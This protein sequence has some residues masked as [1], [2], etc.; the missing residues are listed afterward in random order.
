QLADLIQKLSTVAEAELPNVIGSFRDW[1]FP[2]SDFFVWIPV[3]NRFDGILE[4]II[5]KHDLKHYQ[6]VPFSAQTKELLISV[7]GFSK[8]L[9]DNCTNRNIYAS[10]EHL[11]ELLLTEDADVQEA[12]LRLLQKPAQRLSQQR[13]LKSTLAISQQ[14]VSTIAQPWNTKDIGLDIVELAKP[15]T[16][17]PLESRVVSYQ[18]YRTFKATPSATPST[19]KE[20]NAE[21]KDV[22]EPS[23]PRQS[24]STSSSK[25]LMPAQEGLVLVT[26]HVGEKT[27]RQLF[28]SLADEYGVPEQHK[29]GL[30]H[31]IR[32]TLALGDAERRL[33][34]LRTRLLAI[35]TLVQLYPEDVS[36]T[37]LFLYEPDL[38]QRLVDIAMAEKE[39]PKSVQIVAISTL[40]A[41]ARLRGHLSEVMAALN[42]SANHGPLMI[43]FRKTL[44]GLESPAE[45]SKFPQDYVDAMFSLVSYLTTTQAGGPMITSSGI[46][47][48]L[49]QVLGNESPD[50]I[51]N[52]LR[53]TSILDTIVYGF[54]NGF[55]ILA[56][57]GGLDLVISRIKKEADL[58]VQ[59]AT[60]APAAD[61]ATSTA[62][63]AAA[64]E[65]MDR[66]SLLRA[67]LK[68]VLHMMQTSGTADRLRNLIDSTLPASLLQVLAFSKTFG[69]GVFSLAVNIM[70]TFIHNEPT[71]LS[72]LQELKLPQTF[73]VSIKRH[74]PFSPEVVSA[75]PTA[76]GAICLNQAGLD[77][78]NAVQPMDAFLEI[79]S[80]EQNLRPLLD[81]DVPQLIGGSMDELMRHQTS[82]KDDIMASVVRLTG[83]V[84]DI[85]SFIQ[86]SSKDESKLSV[87]G[88]ADDEPTTPV[89][90]KGDDRE[91]KEHVVCQFVDV[92]ARILEGLFSNVSHAK[93]FVKLNG[94]AELL[95]L[96][97]LPAIP[98]DFATL[99]SSYSLSHLLRL[100][101]EVEPKPVIGAL[102]KVLSDAL[103]E[104]K[105]ATGNSF[106]C[107]NRSP[108][109]VNAA[110]VPAADTEKL[111]RAERLFRTFIL[112]NGYI[113]LL[114]DFFYTP[115]LTHGKS[116]SA[117]LQIFGGPE[118][119]T[120][121]LGELQRYERKS[122]SPG[123]P[124]SPDCQLLPQ[125]AL[126][127]EGTRPSLCLVRQA[128]E[129]ETPFVTRTAL[130][131]SAHGRA[132]SALQQSGVTQ[133]ADIVDSL[134]STVSFTGV[135]KAADAPIGEHAAKNLKYW[136]FLLNQIPTSFLAL[137]QGVF[138]L[139][140]SRR[141]SDGAQR[142]SAFKV[143]AD[144]ASSVTL[145]MKMANE[146]GA[147]ADDFPA[148]R[149]SA[150]I[151]TPVAEAFVKAGGLD[152]LGKCLVRLWNEA[153]GVQ[154]ASCV[155]P[156]DRGLREQ[157]GILHGAI[158]LI[159]DT[160]GFLVDSKLVLESPTTAILMQREKDKSSPDFFDPNEFV[161]DC[162]ARAL[163]PVELLWDDAFLGQCPPNI[164]HSLLKV[165][166]TIVKGE[167][168]TSAKT[169]SS[170]FPQSA[171][172]SMAAANRQNLDEER[173][174]QLVDMGFP[175]AAAE[176]ALVRSMNHVGRAAEYLL[177]HPH[178]VAAA[179]FAAASERDAREP[180]PP[181]QEG[182]VAAGSS[183]AQAEA[184]APAGEGPDGEDSE[185]E[186][187]AEMEGDAEDDEDEDMDEGVALA[188]ALAMSLAQTA[189][190]AGV[191]GGGGQDQ[192]PPEDAPAE[193]N[194][195]G[196][197]SAPPV[198]K[199]KEKVHN[200][201]SDARSK[202]ASF[203][204][205]IKQTLF[206]RCLS[207][208]D[209]NEH[210][211]FDVQKVMA[212]SSDDEYARQ[213]ALVFDSVG[214]IG[215]AA[216][217]SAVKGA[218]LNSRIRLLAILANDVSSSARLLR[219]DAA[220]AFAKRLL[221]LLVLGG[222]DAV[223][224][225]TKWRTS[226]LLLME[227][228]M[229]KDE[230][231]DRRMGRQGDLEVSADATGADPSD[232]HLLNGDEELT[233]TRTVLDT[234]R[235]DSP[236][237]DLVNAALRLLIRLSRVAACARELVKC[238][239]VPVL[240]SSMDSVVF[241]GQQTMI[242]TVLR[243]LFENP[244]TLRLLMENEL[245]AWLRK[246]TLSRAVD[247]ASYVKGNAQM[248][249][250][251]PAA[252][253]QASAAVAKL[254][255]Y[256]VGIRNPQIALAK[257]G[258]EGDKTEGADGAEAVPLPEKP[259]DAAGPSDEDL[260]HL[261]DS[262]AGSFL[263]LLPSA[264]ASAEAA[265][266]DR[267]IRGHMQRCFMLQALTELSS[268]FVSCRLALMSG[269]NAS[270]TVQ[271]SP[272]TSSR[273]V[274]R[275]LR[276]V[277]PVKPSSEAGSHQAKT[278]MALAESSLGTQLVVAL[279]AGN[280]TAF[281]DAAQD[282]VRAKVLDAVAAALK[283]AISAREPA[284]T[285]YSRYAALA[286][287]VSRILAAR[288][289]A[290]SLRPT[291]EP[292]P[293]RAA[294]EMLDKDFVTHLTAMVADVDVH[295]P[296][297]KSVI[298]LVLKP[299]EALSKIATKL[300][301]A[302]ED[303]EEDEEMSDDEDD[304]ESSD[305]EGYEDE[306]QESDGPSE[307]DGSDAED[308]D[309]DL[310]Q[311]PYRRDVSI[312]GGEA[313]EEEGSEAGS[314]DSDQHDD[315]M[316][317]EGD[318]DDEG[319][320]QGEPGGGGDDMSWS[321]VDQDDNQGDG[322][323]EA[324]AE[325]G[326]E[327]AAALLGGGIEPEAVEILEDDDQDDP[328][329]E[330]AQEEQDEDA[331]DGEDGASD[332]DEDPG[333]D[334][335]LSDGVR[336][337]VDGGGDDGG[338]RVLGAPE[339]A[340]E[341][342]GID[343]DAG[344]VLPRIFQTLR[345]AGRRRP[346]LSRRQLLDMDGADPEGWLPER[347]NSLLG[348]GDLTISLEMGGRGADRGAAGQALD[349]APH[350]LL[351]APDQISHQRAAIE[352]QAR[353]RVGRMSEDVFDMQGF[354]D[355]LGGNALQ[356]LQQ[357]LVRASGG[358]AAP[359]TYRFEVPADGA[360]GGPGDRLARGEGLSGTGHRGMNALLDPRVALVH[361]FVP[362][363]CNER[364][365][366]E[367]RLLFGTSFWDKASPAAAALIG[368]LGPAALEEAAKK[369]EEDRLRREEEERKRK[370]DE[371]A[372]K[373]KAEEEAAEAA[374][375][376]LEAAEQAKAAVESTADVSDATAEKEDAADNTAMAGESGSGAEGAAVAGPSGASSR[377][378]VTVGGQEYDIT[379]TGIDP[380][381]LEALPESLRAEVIQQH[382]REQRRSTQ[383]AAQPQEGGNAPAQVDAPA[384]AADDS[385]AISQEFLD[386]LPP[387]IRE[388]LLLQQ[389]LERERRVRQQS[390]L[391][392]AADQGGPIDI[393][394]A[395]F[396]ATLDP[397]LRQVVLL[398]QDDNFLQS[399][400]P[401]IVAE[402]NN[403]R[404]RTRRLAQLRAGPIGGVAR[405]DASSSAVQ[406]PAKKHPKER[407]DARHL[408]DRSSIASLVRLMF[409]PEPMGKSTL[410][411]LL[412]N[413][414]ENSTSR[415]DL[416]SLLLL[417]LVDGSS[418]LGAVDKSFGQLTIRSKGKSAASM[419][420]TPQRANATVA[421]VPSF[422]NVPNLVA[423][424]CLEAL[425]HLASYNDR[426][427]SFFLAENEEFVASIFNRSK[428]SAKKGKG[429]EKVST[430]KY[431]VVVLMSLLDRPTYLQST[432]LM[433][434]LMYLLSTLLRPLASFAKREQA[435]D[436]KGPDNVAASV[437]QGTE[438]TTA[439]R[440]PEGSQGNAAQDASIQ[441]PPGEAAK[442]GRIQNAKQ[443]PQ[444]PQIPDAY[445][446]AVVNVLTAGECSGKTFQY[447]LSVIQ[448]LCSIPSHRDTI[449]AEIM[450]SC[451]RLG[452]EILADLVEL[453]GGLKAAKTG[454]DVQEATL[455][456]FS[457]SSAH[458]A[459]LLRL[460]KTIDFVSARAKQT[461]LTQT[462][463]PIAA[464]ALLYDGLEFAELWKAL[465][466]AL[467][468]IASNDQLAS[469]ATVLL[470]LMEAFMV[471]V[472]PYVLSRAPAP[473]VSSSSG[474]ATSPREANFSNDDVF[475]TFTDA[476][477]KILNEM[478]RS[479]PSLMSG[480]FALLVHNPR[481]MDFDNKRSYFQQQVHKRTTR[482][483]YGTMQLNVRRQYVFEDSF[484]QLQGKSGDE[485]KYGKLSV[486]FYDEEGVD[487]G[488]VTREWFSA[489]ARQMFNPDYALFKPSAA[490][491]VTYQPN[492]SSWINPDHLSYFKFVG[493]V[494]GKAIYDGRL[495]D[496]YFTRSFY[497]HILGIPVDYRDVEAV[498]PEY[499]KSLE[500]ILKNDIT[501]VLDLTMST[502][503]DEFGIKKVVDLMENGRNIAVTEENKAEYVKL[504]T[505]QR[506]TVAIRQQ[507]D[508]FL[509]GLHDVIP[510]ALLGIFNE[511]EL[512]LLIS[513][514]P[515]IDIDDW[516]NNTEYQNYNP[517]SPQI[518]WFWRAVRSFSQEERAKLL[519]FVTGTSKIPLEGFA[520]L[521]G[522]NGVQK[523]QIHRDFSGASR[524][525]SSHT[526]FNQLDLPAY[527]SYE[528]LRQA[529]LIAINE[530]SGFGWFRLS[531]LAPTVLNH[532]IQ[533]S[534]DHLIPSC[535][536][537]PI[538]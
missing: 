234:L 503:I 433:D 434:G 116:V 476:H 179:T 400:P 89:D 202:L 126:L 4:T 96:Y 332:G 56:T 60:S 177:S 5:A 50:Q 214:D 153:K 49:V 520:H 321:D 413:L 87:I 189:T 374:K 432:V 64:L 396:L 137:Y 392:A 28:Q 328:D 384:E 264:P 475:A 148:E 130:Q 426:V 419:P 383:E 101:M 194:S 258:T 301:T 509:S 247:V 188:R 228:F 269:P 123:T 93:D 394:P 490:D 395:S 127:A 142:K 367:A 97:T 104:A 85:A 215:S 360:D 117:V 415:A 487:A 185:A 470:P 491:K 26:G 181:P 267:Q 307:D 197:S 227:A 173:V 356:L 296:T 167:G 65:A 399:L 1:T 489:L 115:V 276:D 371:A 500:W 70:S 320:E 516:K 221:E 494:I 230:R 219:L 27:D 211:V 350:P 334:D 349:I 527:E 275:L 273:L 274:D 16:T 223:A 91:R 22:E 201:D 157:L 445:L 403:L 196:E 110:M 204:E 533:A 398:E 255:G 454:L 292:P 453:N 343:M 73:L 437:S 165:V 375:K 10:Y 124:F 183:G 83:R 538:F 508:A 37:K 421:T 412:L 285:R 288:P 308:Q 372:A 354:D 140:L 120:E 493:R 193:S 86:A 103:L 195:S 33:Q 447:T 425:S 299:L 351:A 347:L 449:T 151:I 208:L 109:A 386:A 529:L 191:G 152:V 472:K 324:A 339:E 254:V 304:E 114:T 84:N 139:L 216:D 294:V 312:E 379:D 456:K 474:G 499:Y 155:A 523:F 368:A 245:A 468:E 407:K 14:R 94:V 428:G 57:A 506:L 358:R 108:E 519:Q 289:P 175:R 370:E 6:T 210:L 132:M 146:G 532:A 282:A 406:A 178:V 67:L 284:D 528:Q 333:D 342:D 240:F 484:H 53:A 311:Q 511:Q 442:Q 48:A 35:S 164:A 38:S 335:A 21:S 478:V 290:T 305:G 537:I 161:V 174:Q 31:S 501:D 47:P 144:F 231:L 518:Q 300:G 287:L 199:G 265:V 63:P 39:V 29:F 295:H 495:L 88:A 226:A 162:R 512:E 409:V 513:G 366:Q 8:I 81:N 315:S 259:D 385:E 323:E 359:G 365:I 521:Q 176:T 309:M 297:A 318:S 238:G 464:L 483:H 460:L 536:S 510:A 154:P 488:G 427:G 524:L 346:R 465:S 106:S 218:M 34:M 381:F 206:T 229:A 251:E 23:T 184:A 243:H 7:L 446:Y 393:D 92:V 313:D 302:I 361:S 481:V 466:E 266:D 44:S 408:L 336:S 190:E 205:R 485:V 80:T 477:R 280:N 58:A 291:E 75:I 261:V 36:Q 496:C 505:E 131:R 377:V 242:V 209:T 326:H 397:S 198:D 279:V 68:F 380:T 517:S 118:N 90:A 420:S 480:S 535:V 51:R 246:R 286:E 145:A 436:A 9:W 256:D 78:Y 159:L 306:D 272:I 471:V 329:P 172:G 241:A 113:G 207:L 486:R 492:L 293:L 232:K 327:I 249:C 212:I 170:M 268:S 314:E 233:L 435:A 283:E 141:I 182:A 222:N 387:D 262:I 45:G 310:V 362:M 79:F 147:H 507:I 250:R 479:N 448:H 422:A 525:V 438:G 24:A 497:K 168:E 41:I 526:C 25:G 439:P 119:V 239:G 257:P 459:K 388:E 98:Y 134:S 133:I 461:S 224:K 345:G 463:P 248:V 217:A 417:I 59:L 136:R 30:L 129:G 277:L 416:I 102:L 330:G 143:V 390:T 429:K 441:P 401:A 158:E 74:I 236:D 418:D 514:M 319:D 303:D 355:L 71:S 363:G 352:M 77:M 237:Q 440:A 112:L 353:N 46:I 121:H 32:V 389:R 2:K 20:K 424:R 244:V 43:L 3:L 128:Q 322:V 187:D 504:V 105:T 473:R 337:E 405:A 180:T 443:E 203:R 462:K 515:D 369:R 414:T 225:G 423:Q 451:Q 382:F 410:H 444:A 76:F 220:D 455:G 316:D 149:P 431:P 402:A 260:A 12:L 340:L 72:I 111:Q 522:S 452:D 373:K 18:F 61:G 62:S 278:L 19:G 15:E 17:V 531:R 376:A 40:E 348:G 391:A 122:V 404:E 502:E 192:S 469:I 364:W 156:T 13:H 325:L 263:E 213:V 498:D 160:V 186:G 298:S 534:H 138:K 331:D 271:K 107:L 55:Q 482:T 54:Q 135:D 378:V 171:I 281:A 66:L 317:E 82:L 42:A 100:L 252:F 338:E 235:A 52:V 11:N 166:L 457:K 530:T 69:P 163:E 357:F 430:L 150:A 341:L 450:R 169:L 200:A 344:G 458:Q 270:D 467:S 95:R 411:R 125:G 99:N 253:V